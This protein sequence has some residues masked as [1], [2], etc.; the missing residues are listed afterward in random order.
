MHGSN[1]QLQ[2]LATGLGDLKERE[3]TFASFFT[4]DGVL[5]H[6]PAR[7]HALARRRLGEMAFW[8]A[9]REFESNQ[10]D[11][12]QIL[13]Y[14]LTLWPELRFEPYWKRFRWKRLVG[15]RAWGLLRPLIDRLR[16]RREP[17]GPAIQGA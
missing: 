7:L 3:E 12:G 9:S 2:Y 15:T 13:D 1:M 5:V 8:A 14:A 6:D 10:M 11:V 17:A 4:R 16:R